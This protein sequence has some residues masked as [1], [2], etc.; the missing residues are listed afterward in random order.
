MVAN[1]QGTTAQDISKKAGNRTKA[2]SQGQGASQ[3]AVSQDA[4][5]AETA[6]KKSAGRRKAAPKAAS[7]KLATKR[8]VSAEERYRMIQEA[9]YFRAEKEGFHCDPWKCWLVAEAEV[10]ALLAGSR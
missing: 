10:D 8:Q 4:T 2:P 1:Q 7:S 3:N 9:A 5:A 6:G